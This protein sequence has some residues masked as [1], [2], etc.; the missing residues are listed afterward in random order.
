M[1][2]SDEEDLESLETSPKGPV[3]GFSGNNVSQ[4]WINRSNDTSSS[5][6]NCS[7]LALSCYFG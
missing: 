2:D 3:R 7:D 1:Q 5:G 6:K 4:V